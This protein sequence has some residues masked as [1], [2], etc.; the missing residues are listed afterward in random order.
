LFLIYS[1]HANRAG[2]VPV[3]ITTTGGIK[4]LAL[5]NQKRGG[6]ASLGKFKLGV[7]ESVNVKVSN[8]NTDG[9]VVVDGLLVVS[10]K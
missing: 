9:F 5:V 2:N 8:S 6:A 7:G 1:P 10:A 4:K 3:A